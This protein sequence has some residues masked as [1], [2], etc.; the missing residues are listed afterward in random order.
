MLNKGITNFMPYLLQALAE[1]KSHTQLSALPQLSNNPGER[2]TGR[3]Q[4]FKKNLRVMQKA[5]RRRAFYRSLKGR[6]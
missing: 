1:M 2:F 4:T 5:Q 6:R 3:S